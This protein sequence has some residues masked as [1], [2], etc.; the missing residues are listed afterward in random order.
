M[1]ERDQPP[2]R[3]NELPPELAENLRAE[4]TYAAVMWGTDHGTAY[5]V[6]APLD[7]I[8]E[9]PSPLPVNV[10]HELWNLMYIYDQPRAPMVMEIF[11]N[12][13][14]GDQRAEFVGLSTHEQTLMMFYDEQLRHRRT[15][16]IQPTEPATIAQM[17]THAE[18]ALAGRTPTHDEFMQAKA[19]VME[20]TRL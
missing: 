19:A 5:V 4:G 14:D 12:P 11:T 13:A 20:R 16:V 17:L 6:K 7:T 3:P 8:S 10:K 2:L 1:T 9:M 15:I 18:A